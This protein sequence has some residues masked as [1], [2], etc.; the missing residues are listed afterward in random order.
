[1]IAKVITHG[2]DRS[3]ALERLDRALAG[4][5]VL[6]LTTNIPYLRELIA[7]P[8]VAAGRLHTTF[9]DERP[10][11]TDPEPTGT[12]L[13]A[14]ARALAA[15]GRDE[16]QSGPDDGHAPSRSRLGADAGRLGTPWRLDGWR[17]TGAERAGRTLEID[18]DLVD[19]PAAD[20]PAAEG[21]APEPVVRTGTVDGVPA[22]HVSHGGHSFTAT[23]LTRQDRVRRA[24]G[25][26]GGAAGP[27][28]PEATSPMPGTVVSLSLIHI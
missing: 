8:D 28:G 6:G 4:T 11:F 5:A 19:V 18:G 10:A 9:L 23:L 13:Q 7:D 25:G 17:A 24:L 14:A 1:M 15:A 21:P 2:A 16:A 26:A 22:A 20:A 12:A 27:G 3:Q